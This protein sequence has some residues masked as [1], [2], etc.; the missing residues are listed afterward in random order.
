MRA[1]KMRQMAAFA[2]AA[3]MSAGMIP[4]GSIFALAEEST[5]AATEAATEATTEAGT[6]TGD[7]AMHT[8][9]DLEG[10]ELEVPVHPQRIAV[11]PDAICSLTWLLEGGGDDMLC[12]T[13]SSKGDWEDYLGHLVYPDMADL[14]TDLMDNMEELAAADPDLVITMTG[15]GWYDDQNEQLAALGIPTYAITSEALYG[16]PVTVIQSMGELLDC[17][18]RADQLIS[19][20]QDTDSYIDGKIEE[21]G[22]ITPQR[23]YNAV[24]VDDMKAW[25]AG[26]ING[27]IIKDL[28]A[29]NISEDEASSTAF[30]MEEIL[31]YDPEVLI[32]SFTDYQPQDFYDNKVPG[33]DWS[34]VSAVVNKKVYG[35]PVCM[36]SWAQSF[37][38]EKFLYKR[39][40]A[41]ILYPDTFP[42][43]E[44]EDYIRS[45]LKD[46]YNYDISDDQIKECMRYAD[47]GM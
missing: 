5:E 23:V 19:Y 31:N 15:G 16:D 38:A 27:Q 25:T 47:N 37:S 13:E 7:V 18:D 36:Q 8:V 17:K 26:S 14:R 22:D 6:E 46:F 24:W 43:S 9:T 3:V 10:N 4:T 2:M 35:A 29:E 39:W 33:Q 1:K 28:K 30:S 20:M 40:M 11:L 42:M 12:L 45:Y 44:T 41:S 32:L 21:L 34:T